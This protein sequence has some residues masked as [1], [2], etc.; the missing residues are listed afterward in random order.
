L[1]IRVSACQILS[2]QPLP[3]RSE[4]GF[5]R[6]HEAPT[7]ILIFLIYG[8]WL[9]LTYAYQAL[10]W[11]VVLLCGSWLIAWQMSLQHEV[12]HG[13][14]TRSRRINDAIGFP[15][16]SLWLPYRI[17]RRCHLVH[18]RD[19]HLTEPIED[20]ES[21]YLTQDQIGRLGPVAYGLLRFCNTFLGRVT[22]GPARGI[23]LFLADE[24]RMVI[25]GERDARR[26]WF[27]HGLGV[28]AVIAWI[29]GI[30]GIPLLEYVALFVYPGFALTLVR[31]FAEHRAADDCD[32]RTA[33][34]E[35]APVLGLLFLYNNLHVVHHDWPGLPWYE[36]PAYY[37]ANRAAILAKNAGLVYDGYLD[38]ARRYFLTPHHEPLHLRCRRPALADTTLSN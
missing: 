33:V 35:N 4:R 11:Y 18:H 30:C 23:L 27:L 3:R 6:R 26:T 1:V 37:R 19:E 21:Y 7:W 34:V 5:F 29:N 24:A 9:A 28:A 2:E 13:H 32:H 36:I 20:P 22:L 38:V 16:L 15:P 17:Y 31:S 8:G 14:P 12:L 25:A 10:P